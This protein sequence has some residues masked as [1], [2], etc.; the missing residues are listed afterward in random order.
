M[1]GTRLRMRPILLTATTVLDLLPMA[2]G[3]GGRSAIWSPMA[4]T[5]CWGLT[6]CCLLRL[7]FLPVAYLTLEDGLSCWGMFLVTVQVGVY[8]PL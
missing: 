8:D 6:T 7:L 4:A 2:L 5:V 1:E 3:W